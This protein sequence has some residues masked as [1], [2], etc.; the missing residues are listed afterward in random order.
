MNYYFD[1]KGA[2][3]IRDKTGLRFPNAA[4]A[5]DHSNDLARRLRD[6]PRLGDSD[7]AISVIDE[8]GSEVHLKD[9]RHRLVIR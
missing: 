3:T 1:I 5:I 6:D 8:S 2:V 4:A 7:L 9:V